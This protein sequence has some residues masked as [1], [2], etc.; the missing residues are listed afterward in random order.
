MRRLSA[1]VLSLLTVV[2]GHILNR[3][4][5]KALLFFSLLLLFA[6]LS[7][8]IY[9]LL[10]LAAGLIPALRQ[11]S[12]LD[13]MPILVVASLAFVTLLSAYVSYLDAGKPARETAVT[14]S[15]IAGGVLSLLISLIVVGYMATFVSINIKLN[16]RVDAS[17]SRVDDDESLPTIRS[18]DSGLDRL[19]AS[20]SH[21]WHN[22]RYSFEWISE[23]GLSPLPQGESYLAG[24]VRYNNAP[25]AGVTLVGI[26][27]DRFRSDE[28]TTDSDGEFVFRV[29]AGEWRLNR[30]NTTEWSNKPADKSFTVVGSANSTLSEDFYHEGPDWGVEGLVLTANSEPVVDARLEIA[31]RDSITLDWPDRTNLPADLTDDSIRWRAVAAASRYQI[32]LQHVTRAGATTTYTPVYWKNTE[33]TALPLAEIQTTKAAGEAV[34]EYQVVVRAF[35]EAGHLLTATPEHF[36]IRSIALE[37]RQ[38]PSFQTF[39]ALQ[40]DTPAFSEQEIEQMQEERKL[41]DA[42]MVLAEA[43][44]PAAARE[45]IAKRPSNHLEERGDTLEGLILTAEGRCEEARLHFES[46]NRKWN[47]ECLPEFYQS[48]C[49]A[50]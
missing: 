28:I 3:R 43:D 8:F 19:Y 30:I 4:P 24:R 34:N 42:A 13:L 48:R 7:F 32:M 39:P 44:M 12:Y 14:A 29:P 2:G 35:D 10:A 15:A 9:P 11:V 41:I 31:I 33:A 37:G 38:I 6:L 23:E 36:A 40:A 50:P 25:A 21:F 49:L 5:D 46:T 1:F 20:N 47:R 16:E 26:F 18:D 17:D 22:L 27:N 45:L